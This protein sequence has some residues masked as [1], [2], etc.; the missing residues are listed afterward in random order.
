MEKFDKTS[1]ILNHIDNQIIKYISEGKNLDMVISE[2]RS[3]LEKFEI[4]I[5]NITNKSEVRYKYLYTHNQACKKRILDIMYAKTLMFN[6]DEYSSY[7][8]KKIFN[9]IKLRD[10][11]GPDKFIVKIP[12]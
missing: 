5:R 3:K 1:T 12:E 7:S 2:L 10:K 9:L 8:Y 6:Y 4:T 11:I